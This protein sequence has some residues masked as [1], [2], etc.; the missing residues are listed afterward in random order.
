[1][2]KYSATGS[3]AVVVTA[4]LGPLVITSSATLRRGKLLYFAATSSDTPADQAIT[5]QIQRCTTAGTSTAITLAVASNLDPGDAT[6]PTHAAGSNITV[7]PTITA[8]SVLLKQTFN[9]KY[10]M[11]YVPP[12]DD[13]AIWFPAVSAN[14]LV[15]DTPVLNASTAN[16]VNVNAHVD[17]R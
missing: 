6:A 16:T 8:N 15:W 17:E 9:Q 5:L 14:G 4:G 3:K 1:M 12:S 10:G 2:P 7:T 13:A 11:V